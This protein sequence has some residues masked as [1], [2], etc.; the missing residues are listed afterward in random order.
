[1][2]H[3]ATMDSSE[4][5]GFIASGVVHV[6]LLV[7]ALVSF[8][9]T[10]PFQNAEET[11]PVDLV[12]DSDVNQIV[13]GDKTAKKVMADPHV[14]KLADAD[15]LRPKPPIA[16]AKRD[17]LSPPPPLKHVDDPGDADKVEPPKPPDEAAAAP[18]PPAQ[19]VPLPPVED[20]KPPPDTTADEPLP[21]PRPKPPPK[22]PPPKIEAKKPPQFKLDQIAKLLDENKKPAKMHEHHSAKLKSGDDTHDPD[23]HFSADDI[24]RLLSHEAP[25]R[26]ASSG[27]R[28]QQ[29]ASLGSPT[30]NAARMSP[31]LQAAMDGWFQDKFQGCWIQPIT[32]PQ[33]P[34]Y[35]PQIR[36]QLNVDGSLAA[37][38]VLMNP[39]DDPAWQAL[40]DS[41]VRAVRKCDPLPVPDKFKTYYDTWRDRVVQF[42]DQDDT[43]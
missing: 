22:K 37:D 13:K 35:I 8:S 30:A 21:P 14:D 36:V 32:L 39:P 26:R 41:A 18:P 12:T 34:K 2:S 4:K 28:L 40:A 19:R 29:L 24:S 9:R 1:M 3:G 33:G 38:P 16:D 17:V 6:A 5:P 25:E 43:M 20:N 27:R 23:R 42:Q 11:V 10:P 7:F 31:S 15:D